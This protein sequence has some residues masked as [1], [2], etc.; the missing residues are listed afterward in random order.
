MAEPQLALEVD[1]ASSL[2]TKPALLDLALFDDYLVLPY[3]GSG[4]P[5]NLSVLALMDAAVAC[6]PSAYANLQGQAVLVPAGT[7]CGIYNVTLMAQAAGAEAVLE[8]SLSPDQE[9]PFDRV[10]SDNWSDDD[11]MVHIPVLGVSYL[12]SQLLSTTRLRLTLSVRANTTVVDT[13]NI[14]AETSTGGHD[15][16][17]VVVGAHLDTTQD[18][19]GYNDNGS[20]AATLLALAL[21]L[22]NGQFQPRVR[23]RFVWWSGQTE[24]GIGSRQYIRELQQNN[25]ADLLRIQGYID[26]DMLGSPNY[27]YAVRNG[28]SALP[29]AVNGSLSLQRAG[30]AFFSR[31]NL[32]VVL[33]DFL[34]EGNADY[35]AFLEAGSSFLD[36]VVF[37]L[38][39]CSGDA[40]RW[41]GRGLTLFSN[42]VILF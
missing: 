20:G 15:G 33:H 13:F 6:Q 4:S 42:H 17:V 38:G 40:R 24:G 8:A 30:Q 19:Q 29:T 3:S 31:N 2:S 32:P 11:E 5:V 23:V 21:T 34:L 26:L 27:V 41:I 35:V 16:A 14:V 25:P 39:G 22:T 18:S 9:L 36:C 28:S 1:P 12:V 7:S 37:F 10:R